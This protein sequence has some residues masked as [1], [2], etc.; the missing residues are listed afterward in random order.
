[1]S[2]TPLPL[3][4]HDPATAGRQ[5]K[6]GQEAAGFKT[7]KESGR[8][9]IED[10]EDEEA[11]PVDHLAG[12]A[13]QSV[14]TSVDGAVR[15]ARGNLKFN[16]NTKRGRALEEDNDVDMLADVPEATIPRKKP[17]TAKPIERLG[18]EFRSKVRP[19]RG[20]ALSG[21]HMSTHLQKAGGD[22]KRKGQADPYSYVSLSAASKKRGGGPKVSLT[23]KKKGSRQG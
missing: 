9:V 22:I 4:A 1:M 15:D 21:T 8:M 18:G 17:K 12:S 3:T 10:G 23:N 19:L 6:P 14:M 5:R 7:D 16:K 2:L 13:Y 11:Q 20:A